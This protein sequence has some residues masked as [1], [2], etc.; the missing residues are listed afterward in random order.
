MTVIM[1]TDNEMKTYHDDGDNDNDH[2]D[3]K[4][5]YADR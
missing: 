3:E 5:Y 1:M 4:I 2:D